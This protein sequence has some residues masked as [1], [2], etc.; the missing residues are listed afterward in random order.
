MW[1]VPCRLGFGLTFRRKFASHDCQ[2]KSYEFGYEKQRGKL[3]LQSKRLEEQA[4]G[5]WEECPD[6]E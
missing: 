5:L 1:V 6:Q 2:G 3:R 4:D